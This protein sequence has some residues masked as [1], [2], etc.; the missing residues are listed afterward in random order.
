MMK[1]STLYDP[2]ESDLAKELYKKQLIPNQ[3]LISVSL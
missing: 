1:M 3:E 2:V